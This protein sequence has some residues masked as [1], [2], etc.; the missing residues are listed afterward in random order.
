MA[1]SD[2]PDQRVVNPTQAPSPE[3]PPVGA[4]TANK[5]NRPV[6]PV[7]VA[8]V[9]PQPKAQPQ[10]VVVPT[11]LELQPESNTVNVPLANN[12]TEKSPP[13]TIIQPQPKSSGG[14]MRIIWILIVVGIIAGIGWAV[15]KLALPFLGN[16]QPVTIT[17]WGL[18]ENDAII[19]PII[20]DFESKNPKIKVEY[21]SSSHRQYRERLTAAINRGEGPDVFRFHN[22]WVPMLVNILDTVP[23][24]IMSVSAFSS[25]FYPIAASDLISGS[26]IYGIPLM[27][28]GLGLYINEDLFTASGASVPS[29]W[30]EVLALVPLLTVKEGE[31]ITTSAIA[32]GTTA[33]ID[34]FSDIVAVMMLQNGVRLSSPTGTEAEEALI[35]Y[36]K[37][38]D[39]AD[40][41]YTWNETLD[42]SVYAFAVGRVAMILAPSWRAF[43]IK[44]INPDLKFKI[45][46][47][48]QLPGK[49]VTWASY[50]V[51]G[52][53]DKSQYKQQA[54][55]FVKFLSES[56]TLTKL[57][58]EESKYRL[59]GEPYSRVDM[60][61]FL[62]NDPYT[63]AFVS[64]ARD[65]KSFPLA[66]RTHDNGLN[67]RLAKYLED[68]VNSVI[69]GSAPSEALSKMSSGF[70]QIFSQYGLTTSAVQQ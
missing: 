4:Q 7:T 39:P 34:H 32:L 59:F 5:P 43:D 38:A 65:A 33:N 64:Q 60:A 37:F 27:I 69:A 6:S 49:S 31:S 41:V 25:A 3:P 62:E 12:Q 45:A 18:W 16:L 21:V 67:D 1:Q 24:E 47:I 54:W 46:P 14:I 28:D 56:E 42:N 30:E 63:E 22:T 29:T 10:T 26:R 9:E 53:S 2:S 61:E 44:Q 13:S 36:R 8:P 51:E 58:S 48:P 55:Q 15:A 17:Y 40:P 57:Y 23:A 20:T 68:A 66:S 35:F 52:V 19:K 70:T 50:W 11:G